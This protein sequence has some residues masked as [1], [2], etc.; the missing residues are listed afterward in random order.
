MASV[1][2]LAVLGVVTAFASGVVRIVIEGALQTLIV[3][4]LRILGFYYDKLDNPWDDENQRV[5]RRFI[6]QGI[7]TLQPAM[8]VDTLGTMLVLNASPLV[9]GWSTV[10]EERRTNTHS[11]RLALLWTARTRAHFMRPER[12][13]SGSPALRGNLTGV[14][15]IDE[16]PPPPEKSRDAITHVHWSCLRTTP[17]ETSVCRIDVPAPLLSWKRLEA[18]V[19]SIYADVSKGGAVLLCGKTGV[20][21]S[22]MAQHLAVRFLQ[23]G[24]KPTLLIGVSLAS[25]TSLEW[26]INQFGVSHKTPLILV[27][28]EFCTMVR[29]VHARATAHSGGGGETTIQRYV[30]CVSSK[31]ELA[32]FLD[33][34]AHCEHLIIV[35]TSNEPLSWWQQPEN[36]YV[37]RD[38][39]FDMRLEIDEPTVSDLNEACTSACAAAGIAPAPCLVA[40]PP[41]GLLARAFLKRRERLADALAAW[42]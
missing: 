29:G 31:S 1:F 18:S 15:A 10:S 28:D 39:R 5:V 37:V 27:L 34:A 26:L 7:W 6:E 38:G 16:S 40:A 4:A 3:G 36:A 11:F 21:K 32:T 8:S 20:G 17:D 30:P 42:T 41:L 14:V 9:V 24:R 12:A 13:V 23:R 19:D 33:K 2:D 25:T 22:S 35:A